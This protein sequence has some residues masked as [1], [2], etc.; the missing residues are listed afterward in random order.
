M[1]MAL[2][3]IEPIQLFITSIPSCVFAGAAMILYGYIASSG[4]KML[5]K[6]DLQQQKNLIIVSTVLSLGVCGLV[7]G[8]EIFS[9]SG[10]ALALV[11]GIILNLILKDKVDF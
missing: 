6:I 8:N 10:T 5:Q 1:L 9:L 2:G 3:F 11:I 7:I 4:I